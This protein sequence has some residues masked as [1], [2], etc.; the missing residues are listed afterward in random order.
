MVRRFGPEP[1]CSHRGPRTA[2]RPGRPTVLWMPAG[3][4]VPHQ[5]HAAG[6]DAGQPYET[7]RARSEAAVPEPDPKRRAAF[8]GHGAGWQEVVADA[9]ASGPYGFL[10]SWRSDMTPVMSLA[11]DTG[12]CTAYL[13]GNHTI[14]GQTYQ[15][16]SVMLHAPPHHRDLHP[17][18]R[19]HP[20]C[21]RSARHGVLQLRQPADRGGR[22]R[23][24]RKLANL[25]EALDVSARQV[26]PRASSIRRW[27]RGDRAAS[28][29]EGGPGAP[30]S[31]ARRLPRHGLAA[32]AQ[33]P[34]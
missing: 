24:R 18:R 13:M 31:P 12:P 17:R 3:G 23:A 11:G 4:L 1:S 6:F 20:F 28:A 19:S 2:G 30:H 5:V 21:R 9:D 32:Y 7:F 33:I 26:L 25:L 22:Y 34:G 10:L 14:A 16:Q 27:S 8:A 29:A 15:D